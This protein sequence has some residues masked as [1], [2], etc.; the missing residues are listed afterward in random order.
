MNGTLHVVVG[1]SGAGKDSLLHAVKPLLPD[2][3]FVQRII[4]RPASAGGEDHLSVTSA[5]FEQLQRSGALSLSWQANGLSYGIPASIDEALTQH[6]QVVFNG[7]R[8][9]L[10]EIQRKYPQVHVIW[11]TADAHTLAQRL[12]QR[13]RE[14]VDDIAHR[15]NQRN[16]HAPEHATVIHNTGSLQKGVHA[17]LCAL[18]LTTP[19]TDIHNAT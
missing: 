4:T 5:E 1:P 7:S 3:I 19:F 17:L 15:L 6:K 9:A 2:A 13:G 16:W 10:P 14:S 12:H 11:V 18:T 8:A